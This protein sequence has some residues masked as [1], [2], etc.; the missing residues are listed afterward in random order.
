M[1][2]DIGAGNIDEGEHQ[3]D[4]FVRQDFEEYKNIDLVCDIRDLLDFVKPGQCKIVRASHVLEH[5]GHG[6]VDSIYKMIN[7]MLKSGGIFH[8]TLPN[9]EY[10]SWSI[11]KSTNR[12][13][14]YKTMVA[15]YGGQKD[16]LD[17]H[18]MGY[19]PSILREVLKRNGFIVDDIIKLGIGW[20]DCKAIKDE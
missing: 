2:L 20:I 13:D 18:K 15:M 1:M 4:G 3:P 7:T 14:A 11:I 17:Y 10:Q 8:I 6:E 12:K 16:R 9:L 19:T 5:F